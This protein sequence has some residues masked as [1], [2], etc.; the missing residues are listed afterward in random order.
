M[1]N[2]ERWMRLAL[3][4]GRRTR[5][6][7]AENPAV[8]CV[9]VR[10][11]HL[12]GAGWTS[13]GGRPH[14]ETNALAMAGEAAGGATAYVTLEPCNHHGSTPPCSGALVASGVAR[15]VIACVDPDP[16]VAGQGMATLRRAGIV[17]ETG[18]L[19]EEARRD[20][21][22]FISRKTHG[23]PHV[24][25]KLAMS[26]DGKIAAERGRPTR[27]TGP[28]SRDRVHLMRAASDAIMVGVSTVLAD[29]PSLTCRLPGLGDRSPVRVVSDSRLTIP[30]ESQLVQTARRVPLWVLTCAHA[31]RAR[32]NQLEA[33]GATLIYCAATHDGKVDLH[34]AMLRLGGRGI[35]V[36]MAEGGAHMARALLEAG[37]IDEVNLF[38][39]PGQLGPHG[40]DALAGMSLSHVTDG[41]NFTR[42]NKETLGDDTLAQYLRPAKEDA[43]FTG[44]VTDVGEVISVERAGSLK[45]AIAS[46]FDEATI[47]LGASIACSGVCL[48]V[49]DKRRGDDGRTV[50]AV[51]VSQ[52]TV[53]RTS[54]DGWTAGTRMNLERAMKLGDE[55]GGH[56]VSGHVD[57]LCEVVSVTP[58]GDSK[59]YRFRASD[60]LACFIASKG[61]IALDGT[62]L[63][64]NDVEGCEFTVNIIPHTQTV[65]TWGDIGTGD[66]VNVEIDMLARYVARLANFQAV[67]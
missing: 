54:L 31:D 38:A 9:I 63:T 36:V 27:I 37:L 33:A 25:L 46:N 34:E 23:R 52:E 2:D 6:V 59:V 45:L 12:V 1:P 43:M 51:D 64:V 53:A 10:D 58:V 65:T 56:I 28:Q 42:V 7:T 66:K 35:N 22:G 62:S 41:I 50:F 5:G 17:V 48:T 30:L 55:I 3:S 29:D 67:E 4:L 20:L 26:A 8:G 11:G 19:E 61:S 47:A 60:K 57:G 24:M 16:R 44:I 32:A 39:A 18:V 13:P 15:V 40:L 21:A 49:V 14:G